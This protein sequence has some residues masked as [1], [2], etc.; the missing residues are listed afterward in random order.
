MASPRAAALMHHLV[1]MMGHQ[2]AVVVSQK[3]LGKVM[4]CEPRT[5]RRALADLLKGNWVQV[6]QIGSTGTINAYV[7]NAAVA[8]GEKREHI[9]RLA[10]FQAQVVADAEDQQASVDVRPDLRRVPIIYPPEEALPVGEGEAGAQI[11]FDGMEPVVT[12]S[13]PAK[14]PPPLKSAVLIKSG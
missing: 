10:V 13:V 2:N 4:G 7:V 11:A 6:V 9:G 8:W 3:T 1:S 12:A 14:E 5:I